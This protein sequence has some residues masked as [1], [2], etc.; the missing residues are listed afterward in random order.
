M[1]GDRQDSSY[2]GVSLAPLGPGFSGLRYR[3]IPTLHFGT[4]LQRVPTIP[5]VNHYGSFAKNC[6]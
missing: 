3:F 2:L 1:S 6:V 4:R 5:N